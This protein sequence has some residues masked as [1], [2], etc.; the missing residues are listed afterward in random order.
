MASVDFLTPIY[1]AP[2]SVSLLMPYHALLFPALPPL[3]LSVLSLVRNI[4]EVYE[5]HEWWEKS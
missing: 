4:I 5:E 3:L 1:P 2:T